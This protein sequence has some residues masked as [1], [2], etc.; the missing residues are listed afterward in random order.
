MYYS[1]APARDAFHERLLECVACA[2]GKDFADDA[3]RL[4]C[5]GCC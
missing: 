4:K 2:E 1:L 3:K 5:A